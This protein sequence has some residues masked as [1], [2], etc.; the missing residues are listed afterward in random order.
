MINW[1][2]RLQ[3]KVTL[4]AIIVTIVALIYKVVEAVGFA[5]IVPQSEI[6]EIA[7]MVVYLLALLGIVVDPTTEGA[8]DSMRALH[9]D[10]PATNGNNY[11][12]GEV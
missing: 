11:I 4:T 10:E 1:K 3:N 6:L 2:L 5:I 8:S 9:Y 7:E 12:E